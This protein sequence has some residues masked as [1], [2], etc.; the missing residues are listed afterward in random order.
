LAQ[1]QIFRI[2]VCRIYSSK[3]THKKQ[4]TPEPFC[5]LRAFVFL[6]KKPSIYEL[7]LLNNGLTQVVNYTENLFQS[8]QVA[9]DLDSIEVDERMYE[10]GV[11]VQ[12]ATPQSFL[13]INGW[14]AEE[15]DRDE[16]ERMF[17]S[18]QKL[19]FFDIQRYVAFYDQSG[20]PQK[21]YDENDCKSIEAINI[22]KQKQQ[23]IP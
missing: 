5:E 13:E 20:Q 11:R 15:I 8:I 4:Q 17:G 10:E 7:K 2:S 19:N 1:Q 3:P 22:L 18:R 21:E 23:Q 16:V 14:S 6:P 9:T 12:P